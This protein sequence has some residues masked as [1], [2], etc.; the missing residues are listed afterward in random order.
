LR[1]T[2]RGLGDVYKRQTMYPACWACPL[3][4]SMLNWGLGKPI[5]AKPVN[6]IA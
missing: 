4:T 5:N 3:T 6:P 1:V 2:S